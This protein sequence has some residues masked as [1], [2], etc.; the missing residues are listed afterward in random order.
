[1]DK[2][3]AISSGKKAIILMA[4]GP[5]L[6]RQPCKQAK[7]K[8]RERRTVSNDSRRFMKRRDLALEN[9]ERPEG[10]F[11]FATTGCPICEKKGNF[12]LSLLEGGGR[13]WRGG[14]GEWKRTKLLSSRQFPKR[15]GKG[16]IVEED[17]LKR[18]FSFSF[19]I[20]NLSQ[21]EVAKVVIKIEFD[22]NVWKLVSRFQEFVS[23]FQIL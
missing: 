2:N 5:S 4:L 6:S 10:I 20:L 19:V 12:S 13:E 23:F 18:K 16:M 17:H 3:L 15:K 11:N 8:E 14:R 21:S 1:M 22:L 9:E 7:G